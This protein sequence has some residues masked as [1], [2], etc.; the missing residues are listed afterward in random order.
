MKVKAKRQRE[1]YRQ[2]IARINAKHAT[3]ITRL[4]ELQSAKNAHK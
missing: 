2:H 3:K 1:K 4:H